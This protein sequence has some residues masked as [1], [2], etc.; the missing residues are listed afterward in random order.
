MSDL[1]PPPPDDSGGPDEPPAPPP[2]PPA[3]S[4]A[5]TAR[6]VTLGTGQT[7]QLATPGSRLGASL[8]DIAILVVPVVVLFLLTF[9]GGLL[10]AAAYE[11]VFTAVKG[12][13]PGK[14][15]TRVTVV[16]ADDGTFPGWGASAGRWVIQFIAYLMLFL[17]GLILHASLLWND[18]HQ[19]WHDLAAGTLV[20]QGNA[21]AA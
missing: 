14:M 12:Q 5:S 19:G 13:T 9:V 11:I 18:R 6:F 1:S 10:L 8:I 15:I 16:S 4:H 7:V 3:H 2:S 21:R 20:I 17:P